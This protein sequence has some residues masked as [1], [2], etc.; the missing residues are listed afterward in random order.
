VGETS[1]AHLQ[2]VIDW[3][4][5][6]RATDPVP[7]G[8]P[9][10]PVGA[11][12]AWDAALG[13]LEPEALSRAAALPGAPFA[14]AAVVVARTVF[15]APLEWAAVLLA[16]GTRVVLKVPHDQP[17]TG[18]ALAT[19][20][21]RHGLPLAATP[22]RAAIGGAEL[23]VAM[24]SDASVAEIGAQS[25]AARRLLFGSRSSVAW[26][27]DPRSLDAVAADA[28]LYDSRGCM[29]PVAVFTPLPPGE[30][31]AGLAAAMDRAEAA[32]PRGAITAREAAEIRARVALAR[33]AGTSRVGPAW[34]VLTLPAE[35]FVPS[36]LPRVLTVHGVADRAAFSAWLARWS[37]S[38]STLGTDDAGLAWPGVRVC[39]PG[40]MQ[41][42]PLDRRHDGVDWLRATL[43][44][45]PPL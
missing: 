2:R 45:E 29:S 30:V 20:A 19:A 18:L 4:A 33:A 44:S 39:A 21:A 9:L 10:S 31:A 22:D 42:P 6:L 32:V 34:G 26:I 23:V 36:P 13:A 15:T 38:L 28:A 41:R 43:N 12:L 7:L 3:L 24:G 40:S 16:R 1:P 35:R 14:S 27:T 17:A 8:A 25:T 37:E 5:E 11:R